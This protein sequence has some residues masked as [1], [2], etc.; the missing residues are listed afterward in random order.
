VFLPNDSP[1]SRA[2]SVALFL[3][4]AF[5]GLR[6]ALRVRYNLRETEAKVRLNP[7]V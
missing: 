6:F 2:I 4:L 1:L 5:V 3:L 7:I